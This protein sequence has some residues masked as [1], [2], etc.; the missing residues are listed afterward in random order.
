MAKI[1]FN[2]ADAWQQA[3]QHFVD[4]HLMV[5]PINVARLRHLSN[6]HP[7]SALLKPFFFIIHSNTI[8]ADELLLNKGGGF[9][10]AFSLSSD[11]VKSYITENF[12]D[13]RDYGN[14][15]EDINNAR[16]W[17]EYTNW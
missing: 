9:D 2:N 1:I 13:Q 16:F 12:I 14:N 17:N 6:N 15:P 3:V 11:D 10:G 8:Q 5:E 4:S 7:I